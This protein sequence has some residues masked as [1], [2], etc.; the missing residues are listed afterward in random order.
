MKDRRWEKI[1]DGVL[2]RLKAGDETAFE[3]L[4]WRY[5]SYVYN[6]ILSLLHDTTIAEDLTQNV[7]LKI[8]EKH[9]CIDPEQGLDAYLFTIARHFVYKETEARLKLIF[10]SSS[11]TELFDCPD[12]LTEETLEAESL[13]D[14]IESLIDQLPSSRKEIFRLSRRQHLTNKEIAQRL[15]ISEK[16]VENQITNALHF[17]KGKLSEDCNLAVLLLLFV[18]G[19]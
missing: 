16:T 15:S 9:A 12:R 5:N 3:L 14:Y 11:T 18:N 4:Y 13:Q 8:W 17:L 10:A 2:R 6:F 7:F 1:D 19:G